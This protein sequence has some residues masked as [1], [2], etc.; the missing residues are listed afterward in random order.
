MAM[1][2]DEIVSQMMSLGLHLNEAKAYKA[3]VTIG[4]STARDVASSSGI[5][6][7]KVYD[8]LYSLENKG[9]V[10]RILGSEPTEFRPYPPKEAIPLLL[11]KIQQSGKLVQRTLES[12]E[13]E[14]GIEGRELVYTI[15]GNDQIR[16]EVRS[17]INNAK[18]Q[19]FISTLNPAIL[20]LARPALAN[21]KKQ[22]IEISLVTSRN[23]I[24]E[25]P[26]FKHYVNMTDLADVSPPG[27]ME[28]MSAVLQDDSVIDAGWNP[29]QM[30]IVIADNTESIAFFGSHRN[31]SK[32][33]ALTVR[34]P[35]I[36]ILQKHVISA[37][38][39]QIVR[40]LEGSAK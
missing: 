8:V 33:W 35:M 37:V 38:L 30:G 34:V 6:R 23:F 15:E 39:A 4:Q 31:Q 24:E 20:S 11:E 14:R 40:F 32:P 29:T 21:A 1:S 3:L 25:W 16:I 22:G 17:L 28:Q 10:R 7:S 13:N 36:V 2:D 18:K 5:P 26:E 12:L 27:I 9:L 19:V